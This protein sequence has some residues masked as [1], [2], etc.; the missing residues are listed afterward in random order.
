MRRM[1]E[2]HRDAD[3]SGRK[4]S[5]LMIEDNR[6]SGSIR[7]FGKQDCDVLHLKDFQI[8]MPAFQETTISDR[9]GYCF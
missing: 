5:K 6:G 1:S 9:K 2:R 8:F 4:Q 3:L 7:P